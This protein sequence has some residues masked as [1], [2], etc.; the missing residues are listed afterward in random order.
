[1]AIVVLVTIPEKEA[2]NLS[3][4]LVQERVCACVNI[5]KGVKSFFWWEGKI[6]EAQ[7]AILIIKTKDSL[8]G[9]LKTLIKNNHS[10]SVP[11]IISFKIDQIN[12]E[13]LEWLNKEANATTFST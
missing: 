5:V 9:K 4:M 1:M 12:Q 7:E 10:Y 6:D 3:K 13:Y 8:F 2:E 11:E